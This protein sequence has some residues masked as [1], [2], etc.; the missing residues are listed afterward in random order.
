[1]GLRVVA[2]RNLLVDS[3]NSRTGRA[4]SQARPIGATIAGVGATDEATVLPFAPRISRTSPGIIDA[5]R[6]C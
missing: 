1:M 3:A 5:P 2:N 4:T 6:S